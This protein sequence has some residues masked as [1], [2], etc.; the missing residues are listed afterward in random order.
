MNS[1]RPY[2]QVL[3]FLMEVIEQEDFAPNYK[4]PSERMLAVKFKA[5]RRSIRLAYESLLAQGFVVRIHGKGH[6]TTGVKTKQPKKDSIELKKI[7]FIVPFLKTQFSQSIL[8][9]IMDFCDEH[10]ID[11]SIKIS[12]GSATKEKRYIQSAITSNAKG[13][14]LF[15]IDNELIGDEFSKLSTSRYPIAVIDRCLKNTNF[16]FISTDNHNAMMDAIKFLHTKKHK[17]LLYI[18]PPTSLASS[19]EER[20]N[21]YQ[22]GINKYYGKKVDSHVLTLP[23]FSREEI[24]KAVRSFLQEHPK[25]QVILTTG[26]RE[27][28]DAVIA[29]VNSL[30]YSIPKDIKLMTFDCDFSSTELALFRPYVIQQDGYQIGYKSA[31]ALYNQ[32]YGD[33][34]TETIQLPISIIDYT[35]KAVCFL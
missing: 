9:G 18:T 2:K 1:L 6:F 15:P 10:S 25:T 30:Q 7:Y 35:E 3:N 23:I 31:A 26:L 21:G 22:N 13:I 11:L 17:N 33:L 14:I 27:N 4:L 19:V 16:S 20:F 32:I 8:N 12:N 28:T 24:I 29:A 5:S 34:H